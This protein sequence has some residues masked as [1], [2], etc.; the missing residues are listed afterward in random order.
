MSSCIK[1]L[2]DYAL[3]EKCCRCGIRTLKSNFH[4][5]L[6]SKDRLDPRCIP[7]MMKYLLDNRDMVKQYYLNNRDRINEYH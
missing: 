4:K 6:S 5:K 7:C 3:A 1:D 2:Y